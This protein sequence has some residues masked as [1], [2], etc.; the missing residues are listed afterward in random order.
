MTSPF[1]IFAL[2]RSRTAWLSCFLTY[3]EWVC[4]HEEIR[5]AR[6]LEDVRAWLKQP[7]VGSAETA[8]SPWWR[9]LREYAPE[10]RVVTVR[11]PVAD[12]VGSLR[13]SGMPLDY[14]SVER[15]MRML[16]HKL[17]QIEARWPGVLSVRFSDLESEKACRSV[18]EHCLPYAHD[19]AWWSALSGRNIQ[20]NLDALLRYY[21]AYEPQLTKL[22]LVAKQQTL[23][24]M[25]RPVVEV[26]GVTFQ[27]ESFDTFYRDGQELFA[28]HLVQVGEP[29]DAYQHKN[30]PL[31]QALDQMGALHITT[32]RSNGRMFGYLMSIL[33]PS[34][35]AVGL[36]TAIQTTFFA[37]SDFRGL[38]MKLQRWSIASLRERGVKEIYMRAGARG[39]GP[40]MGALYRRLGATDTGQLFMLDLK[41]AA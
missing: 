10:T 19:H 20:V 38:G 41:E 18:F 6:S 1:V 2:P 37:S 36:L 30:L 34:L 39:S 23:A 22:A 24:E 9:L 14:A 13:R 28:E 11:R 8:A 17:D 25:S 29:P 5:H 4:A 7:C 27:T 33:S 26:D 40:K 15:R 32:A 3:R 16:D 21:I 35:E 31:F 12:V